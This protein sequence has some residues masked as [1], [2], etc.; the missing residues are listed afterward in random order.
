MMSTG[1]F[2]FGLAFGGGPFWLYSGGFFRIRDLPFNI[3]ARWYQ[4]SVGLSELR[5]L[6]GFSWLRSYMLATW[7]T[8]WAT[9]I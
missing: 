8:V 4:Y 1:S 5:F 3:M 7:L 9:R 6:R 2:E